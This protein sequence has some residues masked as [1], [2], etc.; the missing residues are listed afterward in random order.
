M[1]AKRP[2][3]WNRLIDCAGLNSIA[4]DIM[5]CQF[6]VTRASVSFHS[7]TSKE[8]KKNTE[9]E[10]IKEI[11]SDHHRDGTEKGS[12]GNNQTSSKGQETCKTGCRSIREYNFFHQHQDEDT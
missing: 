10:A 12:K 3:F 1:S 2:E 5:S 4:V 11:E 6:A 9:G 7:R 8:A